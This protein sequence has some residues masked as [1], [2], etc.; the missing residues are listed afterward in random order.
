[1]NKTDV[2]LEEEVGLAVASC[3]AKIQQSYE[4]HPG[5]RHPFWDW[6]EK[7][8][9]TLQQLQKFSLLYY[10]HVRIF[11][12]RRQHGATTSRRA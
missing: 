10:K 7:G 12:Q 6:M 5:Y 8:T 11:R 4:D 1:M 2:L 9:Y 3:V